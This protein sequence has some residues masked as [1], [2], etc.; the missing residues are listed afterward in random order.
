MTRLRKCAPVGAVILTAIALMA[1]TTAAGAQEASTEVG[2]A[3]TTFGIGDWLGLVARLAAVVGVIWVAVYGMR[4][5]VRRMSAPGG[6]NAQAAL[7][8]IET[9]TLGSNRTL[10]LVRL[11]NRAVLV[12]ATQERITQLLTVDD[13][14]ELR[15]LTER[16]EAAH[17]EVRVRSG[18][19]VLSAF[20]TGLLAMQE[21][22]H[23]AVART[24]AARAARVERQARDDDESPASGS[25]FASLRSVMDRRPSVGS[26]EESGA[27]A[28]PQS[29]FE[30]TLAE[31]SALGQARQTP[32]PSAAG[33]RARAG[34]DRTPPPSASPTP[35]STDSSREARVAE[36]QRAIAAARKQAG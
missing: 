32:A 35:T 13:P 30:R 11:G 8:V 24:R 6:R 9:H 16:P 19:S 2:T 34:Y 27:H 15:R 28:A 33:L 20:R 26:H 3:V 29:L 14:E 10:H 4:W 12:G 31:A 23:Q 36:L 7:E 5:Y 18:A 17:R 22:R 21:Q 1:T 25:R